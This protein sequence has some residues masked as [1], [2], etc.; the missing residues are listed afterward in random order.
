MTHTLMCNEPMIVLRYD[1][2]NPSFHHVGL[3]ESKG[4]YDVMECD[5]LMQALKMLRMLLK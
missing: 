4:D 5:N 3:A 2:R 1:K